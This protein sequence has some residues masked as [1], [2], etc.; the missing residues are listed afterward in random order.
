MDLNF[1]VVPDVRTASQLLGGFGATVEWWLN[2]AFAAW[3]DRD[4]A[5]RPE[6]FAAL[7]RAL[8]SSRPGANDLLFLPLGGTLQLDGGR[9]QGGF[10]GLRLDHTR[11]DMARAI[12]EG[13][14]YEVRW[15]L[16]TL[17]EA[18]QSVDQIW[19]SGGAAHSPFW[20]QILASVIDIPLWVAGNG[21]WPARGA[22][23]LAGTGAGLWSSL[24]A[25]VERWRLP[26][27]CAEPDLATGALYAERYQAYRNLTSRLKKP[28]A[29]P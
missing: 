1:H 13:V 24:P 29:T 8:E 3:D 26:L 6:L 27:V 9:S 7:N 11:A 12:L 17:A 25:A 28:A 20:P 4:A 19:M 21:N 10:V 23:M 16:E 18:G 15:A 22:A 14:A 2:V 5:S